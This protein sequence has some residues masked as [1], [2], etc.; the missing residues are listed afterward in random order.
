[1]FSELKRRRSGSLK[2]GLLLD[3]KLEEGGSIH[4]KLVQEEPADKEEGY[5]D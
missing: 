1:L 5:M 2:A 3:S 4:T